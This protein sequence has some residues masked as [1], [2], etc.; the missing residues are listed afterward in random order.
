MPFVFEISSKHY[1]I[2]VPLSTSTNF[3]SYASNKA[4]ICHF[5]NDA[6]II[7]I[8]KKLHVSKPHHPPHPNLSHPISTALSLLLSSEPVAAPPYVRLVIEP[9]WLTKNCIYI[10]VK[11]KKKKNLYTKLTYFDYHN[12]NVKYS[13][14]NLMEKMG[15]MPLSKKQFSVS[16]NFP[17]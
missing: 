11:K 4:M 9:P 7:F 12:K 13:N 8:I 1:F 10:I 3:L 2:L 17:N 16:P 6:A 15:K 14:T 5:L